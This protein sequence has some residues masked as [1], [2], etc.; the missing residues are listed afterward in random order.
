MSIKECVNHFSNLKDLQN[1]IRDNVDVRQ[2]EK[3]HS[4][5]KSV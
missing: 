3:P 2:P 1:V 5:G 4:S